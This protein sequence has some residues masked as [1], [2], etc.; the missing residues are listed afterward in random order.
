MW[1]GSLLEAIAENPAG[2]HRLAALSQ[3]AG[4][5]ERHLTRVFKRELGLTPARYVETVH[6]EAA[7]A[8]LE[9]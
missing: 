7:R 8:M 9:I 5:S 4:F 6:L 2:D 1:P 3:Q